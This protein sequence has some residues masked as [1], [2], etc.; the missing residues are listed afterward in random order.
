MGL[1][2]DRDFWNEQ[3]K[4]HDRHDMREAPECEEHYQFDSRRYPQADRKP[5]QHRRR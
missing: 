2:K 5:K 3:A 4:E 1:A